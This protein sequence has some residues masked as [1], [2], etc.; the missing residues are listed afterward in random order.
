MWSKFLKL[1]QYIRATHIF[2]DVSI[3]DRDQ[4]SISIFSV[5]DFDTQGN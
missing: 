4:L 3:D 5:N 1:L 2:R